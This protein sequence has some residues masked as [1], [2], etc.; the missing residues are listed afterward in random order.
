M[1]GGTKREEGTQTRRMQRSQNDELKNPQNEKRANT[2][3]GCQLRG[4][5]WT[6]HYTPEG[7]NLFTRSHCKL[8]SFHGVRFMEMAQFW[9]NQ[10]INQQWQRMPWKMN[11]VVFNL[12]IL[13]L[14]LQFVPI[15]QA[16]CGEWAIGNILFEVLK[17]SSEPGLIIQDFLASRTKTRVH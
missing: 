1:S 7:R 10:H 13:M 9:N 11:S 12:R 3:G 4:D 8:Q 6:L 14:G 5:S 16:M 2:L 17:M 15:R